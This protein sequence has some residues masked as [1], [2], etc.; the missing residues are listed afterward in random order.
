MQVNRNEI[1]INEKAFDNKNK[2]SNKLTSTYATIIAVSLLLG[3]LGII[4]INTIF[5]SLYQLFILIVLIFIDKKIFISKIKYSFN[6]M[7]K[8]LIFAFIGFIFSISFILIADIVYNLPWVG[9]P[10]AENSLIEHLQASNTIV[11][12]LNA[13]LGM[14]IFTPLIE[15]YVFRVSFLGFMAG[16]KP[17]KKWWPYAIIIVVFTL[18][19][20]L[21]Y[22]TASLFQMLPYLYI[23]TAITLIYKFSNCNYVSVALIHVF[24]N[25]LALFVYP[26][27]WNSDI[28]YF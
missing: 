20:G 28:S 9:Y 25:S 7:S 21:P 4:F 5:F 1:K 12:Y 18:M 17:T 24:N 8:T 23:S 19:H 22:N 11:N 2:S 16:D 15:E 3:N 10:N 14:C 26:L 6:N 27:F 13:I